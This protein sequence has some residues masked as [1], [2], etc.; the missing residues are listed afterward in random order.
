MRLVW[1]D[2]I[3]GSFFDGSGRCLSSV[4]IGIQSVRAGG[5]TAVRMLLEIDNTGEKVPL[6]IKRASHDEELAD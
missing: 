6:V 2:A 4:K 5:E 3:T 1:C